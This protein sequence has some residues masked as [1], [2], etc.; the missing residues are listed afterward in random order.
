MIK[1]SIVFQQER[2]ENK[3]FYTGEGNREDGYKKNNYVPKMS[4]KYF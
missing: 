2:M 1:K 3:R 4:G